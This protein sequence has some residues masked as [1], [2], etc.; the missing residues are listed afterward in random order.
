V[1]FENRDIWAP[2]VLLEVKD[3]KESPA[4]GR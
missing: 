1:R 2:G 3:G 4:G